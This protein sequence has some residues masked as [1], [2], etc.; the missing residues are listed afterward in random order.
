MI[1]KKNYKV[2]SSCNCNPP[3]TYFW[4]DKFAIALTSLIQYCRAVGIKFVWS[5]WNTSFS[6][7]VESEKSKTYDLEGYV[8]IENTE[9]HADGRDFVPVA[10]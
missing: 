1:R 9:W 7:F 3:E 5:T 2:R 6:D 8:S 4:L 10:D